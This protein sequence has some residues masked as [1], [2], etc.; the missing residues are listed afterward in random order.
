MTGDIG[1]RQGIDR[2]IISFIFQKKHMEHSQSPDLFND[3]P[4]Q[5]PSTLNV[6]TILTFIGCGISYCFTLYGAT[7]WSHYESDLADMQKR[8]DQ[9]GDSGFMGKMMSGAVEQFQK[10]YANR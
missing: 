2:T 10:A 8:Q 1:R 5:L 3:R 7:R 6:L 4:K 9:V